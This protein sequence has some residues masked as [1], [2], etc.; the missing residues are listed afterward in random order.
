M[1]SD[2][3]EILST[4]TERGILTGR[5]EDAVERTWRIGVRSD[6]LPAK[7]QAFAL[8]CVAVTA[9]LRALRVLSA[10]QLAVLLAAEADRGRETVIHEPPRYTAQEIED[11]S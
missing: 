7:E 11:H 9:V 6:L 3:P 4:D 2:T 5:L 10:R 8:S 1:S